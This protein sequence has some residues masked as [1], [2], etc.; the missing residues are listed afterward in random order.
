MITDNFCFYLQNRLIQTSQTGG[1]WYSDTSP[2]RIPCLQHWNLL[3]EGRLSTVDLLELTTLYIENIVDFIS[4]QATLTRRSTGLSLPLQL[5]FLGIGK[6]ARFKL[7]TWLIMQA[8]TNMQSTTRSD[9]NS[10][11]AN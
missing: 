2:F 5:V 6:L 9:R 4:K 8:L 10:G 3:S 7:H 1:Q 11:N